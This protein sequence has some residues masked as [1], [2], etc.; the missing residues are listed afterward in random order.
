VFSDMATGEAYICMQRKQPPTALRI[1]TSHRQHYPSSDDPFDMTKPAVYRNAGDLLPPP[2]ARF[3]DVAESCKPELISTPEKPVGLIDAEKDE[4]ALL[5][6][7]A[8]SRGSV[9]D[10]E[11][12]K[13]GDSVIIDF[14]GSTRE[15]GMGSVLNSHRRPQDWIL[16]LRPAKL[17]VC[18]SPCG[19]SLPVSRGLETAPQ[20]R[21]CPADS[22][23]QATPRLRRNPE[24]RGRGV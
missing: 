10:M 24:R 2:I 8:V 9:E 21:L 4:K 6:W 5:G 3:V 23:G 19:R 11:V 1:S 7:K 13:T 15:G 16:Q 17:Q 22:H 18:N 12:L 14:G 20:P